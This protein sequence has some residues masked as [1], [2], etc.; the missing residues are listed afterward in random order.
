MGFHRLKDLLAK[1]VPLEQVA[2]RQDGRLVC[3][4]LADLVDPSKPTHSWH[5]NQRLLHAWIAKRIPLLHQVNPQHRCQRIRRAA[6][7]LAAPGIVRFDQ[8]GQRMPGHY[9]VHVDQELLMFGAL[10][11]R[12]LLVVAEPEFLASHQTSPG[13]HAHGYCPAIRLSFPDSP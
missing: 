4:P 8:I 7:L 6:T 13:L 12:G 3:D 2:K 11:G 1:V 5:L 10:L 9:L